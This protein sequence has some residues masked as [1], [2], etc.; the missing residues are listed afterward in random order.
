LSAKPRII[1]RLIIDH[2]REAKSN[3]F[4]EAAKPKVKEIT[5]RYAN[6]F[7]DA[8]VADT[9]IDELCLVLSRFVATEWGRINES[10]KCKKAPQ[11]RRRVN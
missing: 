11:K 9:D 2:E 5:D 7:D 8:F 6:A 1:C 10:K 4:S 3:D